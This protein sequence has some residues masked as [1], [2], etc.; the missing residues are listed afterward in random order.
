MVCAHCEPWEVTHK[1]PNVGHM[2]TMKD[3]S[4]PIAFDAAVACGVF[5]A[6]A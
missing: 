1:V 3:Y 2:R 6:H 5:A 4:Q